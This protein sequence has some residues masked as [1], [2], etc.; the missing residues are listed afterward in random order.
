M[1]DT[2]E[3]DINYLRISI[4]D[5]C[6]LR[7]LYCM[8]A[9]GVEMREHE[10]ILRLEEIVEIVRAWAALGI[11][12]IRIT[13][14]EPLVRR[15]VV[16]FISQ[17]K[18]IPGIDDIALTTNG[19]LLGPMAAELKAAGLNR[20]NVSLDTLRPERF[21]EL[22]RGGQLEKVWAGLAAALEQ[23]LTPVKLNMVVMR[24]F[25][26]D[27]LFDFVELTRERE[28]HVRFIELM[29]I[30]TADAWA[31][32]RRLTMEEILLQLGRRY[33]LEPGPRIAGWGPAKY[34]QVPGY[35]GTVGFISPI[36]QHFCGT[37]NRLRLTAE[38]ML[39]PC[40]HARQEV[41]IKTPLRR[42]AGLTELV[43]I[44]RQVVGQ[45]PR[46]HS[47]AEAGWGDNERKMFQ[48]GG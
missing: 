42:G 26:D 1:K 35:R 15:G 18:A 13:G 28:L 39:R 40:L 20:V 25:N 41:D 27:E 19:I 9:E 37:C 46:A 30:G 29:P 32:Q 2:F 8:P 31:H 11:S 16:D 10:D 36:S 48:I 24:G 21:Q 38:G 43:D 22:T 6:N 7:C 17:L 14:G 47:M 12:K 4:T 3:R 23:G 34:Y 44:F 45:K 33:Q 5:R